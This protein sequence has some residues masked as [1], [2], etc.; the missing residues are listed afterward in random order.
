[1]ATRR[2]RM[3]RCRS[4]FVCLLIAVGCGFSGSHLCADAERDTDVVREFEVA[5]NRLVRAVETVPLSAA[6]PL[7]DRARMAIEAAI[8]G[9]SRSPGNRT[10]WEWERSDATVVAFI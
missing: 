2:H 7:E 9:F 4:P 1:M 6:L 8:W 10:T 5:V 3:S